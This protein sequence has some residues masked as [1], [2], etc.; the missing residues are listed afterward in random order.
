MP[1]SLLPPNEGYQH[2]DHMFLMSQGRE[3]R[4]VGIE[5]RTMILKSDGEEWQINLTKAKWNDYT[6]GR[7]AA[8]EALR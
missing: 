6:A 8:L 1:R 5:D 4:I 7:S 3:W 2:D